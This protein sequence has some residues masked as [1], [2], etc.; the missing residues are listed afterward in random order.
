MAQQ[1]HERYISVV[2]IES[3]LLHLEVKSGVPVSVTDAAEQPAM[4]ELQKTYGK[5]IHTWAYDIH[6]DLPLGPPNLMM[7]YTDDGQGPPPELLK[8]RDEK[9]GMNTAAKKELRAG[10]LPPYEKADGADE[11]EK[12]GKAV[13]FQPKEVNLKL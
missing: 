5:T 11:W 13:V 2:Q 7:A 1:Y 9:S 6:P 4:L 12:T 10:Y 3:G 8:T